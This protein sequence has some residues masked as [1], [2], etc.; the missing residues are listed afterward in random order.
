MLSSFISLITSPKNF[1]GEQALIERMF[2]LNLENLFLRKPNISKDLIEQWLIGINCKWHKKILPWQG[3]AHS[4]EELKE[5]ENREIVLLGPI[6]D[7]ISKRGYKSKFSKEELKIGIAEWR[8][9]IGYGSKKLY[10]LGG[11]NAENICELKELGFDGAAILG[12]VWNYAD[13]LAAFESIL[14]AMP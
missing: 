8:R 1:E 13:P 7:S 14:F 4:F 12:G 9:F 2:E 10:A 5:M 11:I 6:F 3:S